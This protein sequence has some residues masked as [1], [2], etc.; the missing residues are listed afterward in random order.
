VE[1]I[2]STQPS[3]LSGQLKLLT[4]GVSM[5]RARRQNGYVNQTG[6]KPKSWTGYWYVYEMVDGVEKRRKKSQVLGFCS[7]MTKGAAKDKLRDILREQRPPESGATFEQWAHWYLKTNEGRWSRN[8]NASVSSIFKYQI[9]PQLGKFVAEDIRRSDVQQAINAIAANSKSQSESVLKKCVTQIRAVFNFAIEDDVLEKNPALKIDMPPCREPGGEF[10]TLE[11]CQRLLTV[12][13]E[14]DQLILRVFMVCGLRPSELFALRVNDI[15]NGEL[16]IDE[17]IV[18]CQVTSRTK[19]AGSRAS[20][21]LSPELESALRFYALGAKLE[22]N[23]FLFPSEAGTAISP[24]NFL[25]RVLQPLG[26]LAGIDHL[27]HQMLRRTTATHFQK[28]ASF[29]S[30]QGLMRHANAAT[31]MK[32]YQKVLEPDL[33]AGVRSWDRALTRPRSPGSEVGEL[34]AFPTKAAGQ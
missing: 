3:V 20:V 25:D 24:D 16:R 1:N 18:R 15:G 34:I 12:G 8:W 2:K 23:D 17:T 9:L 33:C 32:H 14:R 19:T 10:L 27:T 28:H 29:K 26:V 21:P 13:G 31:T 7:E 30:A 5:P 6:I 11:E 4:I 22:E